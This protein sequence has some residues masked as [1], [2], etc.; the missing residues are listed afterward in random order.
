M[1][2]LLLKIFNAEEAESKRVFLLILLGA[3]MGF[4][5][6][7]LAVGAE[8]LFLNNFSE[9]T[10]LPLAILAS[11]I[12]GVTVTAIFNYFQSKIS[13]QALS[14]FTLLFI[15]L[16]LGAVELAYSTMEDASPL[17]FFTFTI[18][19]PFTY[20]ILLI[21][22]GAFG[23]LFDLRQSKRII[24][25]IDTGQLTASI[26]ALLV[27]IPLMLNEKR[28]A[29]EEQDLLTLSLIS[30]GGM[31]FAFTWLMNSSKEHLRGARKN[32][33]VPYKRLMSEKYVMLMVGF[34]IISMIAVNFIDYTFFSVASARFNE[35][36]LALFLT[37]FN[38]A[39]I[40][41]SF[42]FQTFATDKIIALYGLK[43]SL[44]INP[45]VTILITTV[46]CLVGAALGYTPESPTFFAFFVMIA[47]SRLLVSSLKDAL[48]EP[49]FKL[50]FLPLDS[51]TRFDIQTKIQGVVNAFAALI[52]GSVILLLSQ[53]E[54]FNLL[55]IS[56]SALPLLAI[57][58][59][60][61]RY[62]HN[63]YRLT[64]QKTLVKNK[65][66]A[67][68]NI[69]NEYSLTRLLRRQVNSQEENKKLFGLKLM[70]K[71]EPDEFEAMKANLSDSDSNKVKAYLEGAQEVDFSSSKLT[72]KKLAEKALKENQSQDVVPVTF[73]QLSAL[74]RSLE[75]KN[76][77][78]AAKIFLQ[79]ADAKNIFLL[80][81]LLK[82]AN[83]SVRM[84][85][86]QT[87]RQLKRHE[88]WNVLIDMLDSVK[89]GYAASAA[90]IS[91]GDAVLHHLE[92][93]FH[94]SGQ[95][96]K[97]ML[98]IVRIMAKIGGDEA[99][100]LLFKKI[101]YP[102]KRIVYQMLNGF[103]Y[104][105]FNASGNHIQIIQQLI[106]EEIGK[107][108]WNLAAINELPKEETYTLLRDAIK[109]EVNQ[110]Y[111]QIFMLLSLLYDAES[112]SLVKENILSETAEGIAYGMELLDMF[113]SN[114]LKPKLFPLVDDISVNEKVNTLVIYYPR[115]HFELLRLLNNI[116]NR[117]YN[118]LSRW[119]KACALYI[120][121]F[122]DQFEANYAVISHIFNKDRLLKEVA[123]W[124]IYHRSPNEFEKVIDRI[125]EE[126]KDKL[127]EIIAYNQLHDGLNDGY[128]LLVEIVMFLKKLDVFQH[129]SGV[130][131]CELADNTEIVR[132]KTNE[133][134]DLTQIEN[135][136]IYVLAEG[137]ASLMN[138]DGTENLLKVQQVF[139]ELF[140]PDRKL[141]QTEL[142]AD[143]DSILFKLNTNNFYTQMSKSREFTSEF[144][145]AITTQM[146]KTHE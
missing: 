92:S 138:E 127:V 120:L 106:D 96:D 25:G 42:L 72:L 49:A 11:G 88:T 9:E 22:W 33:F 47:V 98:A 85:A 136:A 103:G 55:T 16:V 65:E 97:I 51:S 130:Q 84:E 59:F 70:E 133:S 107:T 95:S 18:V 46:A 132:L 2:K 87:A 145:S 79:Y 89:Y 58:Y 29:F 4:F 41:F 7:S 30:V 117:D 82:D 141:S 6:S 134:I 36:N 111:E 140:Q 50:Y 21:F 14:S 78:Y 56:V 34:V 1:K 109:E 80:I 48:D 13:F 113:L 76:R 71:L 114:D 15:F 32:T 118:Q 68:G 26:I 102:D 45:I 115:E 135:N 69:F 67:T 146:T 124:L 105:D 61:T 137:N 121:A 57:W 73:E 8:A 37:Y 144:F 19:V 112:V 81:D 100:A 54:R 24:G 110:N 27:V 74:S 44:L 60:V 125:P 126:E 40:I 5:V 38:G 131:L 53:I 23:R 91:A 10:D 139:G 77:L 75:V 63:G 129:I 116:I 52:A 28:G 119:V 128:Y 62:M 108:V 99:R 86:I 31:L 101:D 3:F 142:R 123:A 143:R 104:T 93:A 83:Q 12:I 43:V 94:K 64:L 90:L 66:R 122:H 39:V 20:L 17:Y 35:G